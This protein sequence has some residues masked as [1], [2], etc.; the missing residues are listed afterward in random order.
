[1]AILLFVVGY[2][3]ASWIPIHLVAQVEPLGTWMGFF[4]GTLLVPPPPTTTHARARTPLHNIGPGPGTT[5]YSDEGAT[6]EALNLH[7]IFMGNRRSEG[8][9]EISWPRLIYKTTLTVVD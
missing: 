4:G 1:M 8:T 2:R 6:N 9:F 7:Y 5:L 3:G